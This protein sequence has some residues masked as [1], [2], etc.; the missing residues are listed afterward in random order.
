MERSRASLPEG[1]AVRCGRVS[2]LVRQLRAS[3]RHNSSDSVGFGRTPCKMV[4]TAILQG[5]SP[6]V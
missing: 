6:D 5:V 4:E 2:P 1:A 3:Q